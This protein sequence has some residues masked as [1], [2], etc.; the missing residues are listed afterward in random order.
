[1]NLKIFQS[2]LFSSL[3]PWKQGSFSDKDYSQYLRTTGFAS[4][5]NSISE[6]KSAINSIFPKENFTKDEDFDIY[7]L[8]TNQER[9]RVNDPLVLIDLPKAHNPKCRFYFYL[10]TNEVTRLSDLLLQFY[11]GPA[12]QTE[13]T[14][15]INNLTPQLKQLI[16]ESTKELQSN[17]QDADIEFILKVF[18][19][20]LVRFLL[21]V[22]N[23][24]PEIIKSPLTGKN[25]QI[26]HPIPD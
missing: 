14:Y 20:S 4:Q 3:R 10:I 16:K 13:K 15:V 18:Q 1:M 6:F 7:E 22:E 21:E 25:G 5:S 12:S 17:S 8:N 23:L 24:F 2:I 19:L 11:T 26:D 9:Q